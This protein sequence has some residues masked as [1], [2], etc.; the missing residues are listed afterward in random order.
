M[1][2]L[3]IAGVDPVFLFF[4]VGGGVGVGLQGCDDGCV[5]RGAVLSNL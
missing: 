2:L 1:I 5:C 4:F 3:S